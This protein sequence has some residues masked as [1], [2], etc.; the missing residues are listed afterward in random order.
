MRTFFFAATL[1]LPWFMRRII[2]NRCFGYKI[3][4][5][6]RI[7]FSWIRPSFLEMGPYSKIGH[8]NIAINLERII[9][10]EYSSIG[11]SNWITG[12]Q[13]FGSRHFS[14]QPDRDPSLILGPHSAITKR[15]HL[16]CTNRI[17]IGAF[18]TIAGY[19][20][21]FLTHSINIDLCRQDSGP[22]KIG[23][24]TFI[25]TNVV[26]LPNSSLPNFSIL[27]AKALLNKHHTTEFTLY[28]GV[29][30]KQTC[31]ISSQAK[32]FHRESGFV[33]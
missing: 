9:L 26:I 11:R 13:R 2:L 29:P 18:S 5:S 20:S 12:Y 24:R 8:L 31:T 16:D 25:G 14:H 21:Q 4:R 6:A 19:S 1:I 10:K 28:A 15:H 17:E 32:Y 27:G 33:F 30:A 3:H 22:I 23:D 7:G